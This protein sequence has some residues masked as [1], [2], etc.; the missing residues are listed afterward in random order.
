MT[1]IV[2]IMVAGI[3][4]VG[5]SDVVRVET[6]QPD[7]TLIQELTTVFRDQGHTNHL[8]FILVQ[9]IRRPDKVEYSVH[10]RD[11]DKPQ[12]TGGPSLTVTG[13]GTNWTVVASGS[14]QQ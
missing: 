13:N 10:A 7:A 1:V 12:L 2:N 6:I 9:E 11:L 4:L 14:W 3:L 8:D 5:C